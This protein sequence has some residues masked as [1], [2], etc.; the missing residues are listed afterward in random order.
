MTAQR[1]LPVLTFAS[2][3]DWE[4]WLAEQHA[5]S[6]GIWLKIA[7]KDSGI[8]SVN[9]T[10]ALDGALCYGWIDG[11]RCALD[12]QYFLQKFTPRGRRSRWSKINREKVAALEAHG[13]MQPAGQA[14]V[15][16]AQQ[17]G[18]WQSAYDSPRTASVPEDLQRELDANPGAAAFFATLSSVNR[19]AILYRINDARRPQTRARRISTFIEMLT[20]GR[21]LHS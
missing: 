1:E 21:V 20:E 5:I 19:Y 18:R 13:R 9:Y 14:E 8:A 12:A 10:E 6:R 11:Q 17:D 3:T 7:K 16:R 2:A 4:A 15:E